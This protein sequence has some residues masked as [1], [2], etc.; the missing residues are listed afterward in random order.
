MFAEQ[1]YLTFSNKAA[2]DGYTV[3]AALFTGLSH[4]E[5]IHVAN[6]RR[7]MEK[8]GYQGTFPAPL[9]P[10]QAH[11]TLLN[12]Q[13]AIEGENEEFTSMYPSFKKQISN[14]HGHEF[15]AKIALLSI[16]WA[17]DSEREHH[18]LLIAAEKAVAAGKDV[19]G[20]DYYLC[21]VC[22]NLHFS[23]AFP[24][25]LCSVCGHDLSFYSKVEVLI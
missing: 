23:P 14:K 15:I 8:N 6:H 16:K 13:Q 19:V 3:V 21:A 20:G 5:S 17:I 18:S 2:G 1:Q 11:S 12:L 25:E 7:A 9:L 22:G 10:V 4:A 24:K